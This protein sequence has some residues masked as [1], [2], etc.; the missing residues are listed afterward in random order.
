MT[1]IKINKTEW[2]CVICQ[3]FPTN[4]IT[5][6]CECYAC[7]EHLNDGSVKN[8]KISCPVCNKDFETSGEFRTP[9]KTYKNF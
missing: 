8:G 4:P 3:M 9:H 7:E 2:A 6:N 5:L 1:E